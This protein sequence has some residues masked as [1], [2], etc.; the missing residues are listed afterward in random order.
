MDSNRPSGLQSSKS[1]SRFEPQLPDS[2]RNQASTLQETKSPVKPGLNYAYEKEN[3]PQADVFEVVG[4]EVSSREPAAAGG[5]RAAQ[6]GYPE[7]FDELPIELISL[8]DR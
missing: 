2:P 3:L 6:E 7:G 4:E 8:A 5:S 1:F